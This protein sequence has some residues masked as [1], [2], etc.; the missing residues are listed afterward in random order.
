M[1]RI[2]TVG[3]YV[4]TRIATT[5]ADQHD[6]P[7]AFQPGAMFQIC[8]RD[9]DENGSL[10]YTME[11]PCGTVV[12]L[13]EATLLDGEFPFDVVDPP[14]P[15]PE[16]EPNPTRPYIVAGTVHLVSEFDLRVEAR[17]RDEAETIAKG[18]VHTDMIFKFG[19]TDIEVDEVRFD[20]V[21]EV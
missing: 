9:I 4:T 19:H 12:D 13:H 2:P 17:T 16:P 11:A 14:E 8:E 20:T 3:D 7:K 21:T 15:T 5:G 1:T 18:R 6:Q 10:Y